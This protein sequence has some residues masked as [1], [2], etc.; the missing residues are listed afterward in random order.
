MPSLQRSCQACVRS[1]RRCDR[2]T[3]VCGRCAKR[4]VC[5]QYVNSPGQTQAQVQDTISTSQS[6]S[7]IDRPDK[8]FMPEVKRTYDLLTLDR[9]KTLLLGLPNL[10]SVDKSTVFIQPN[11]YGAGNLPETLNE[12]WSI[13][14]CASGQYF[15][16]KGFQQA[17]TRFIHQGSE[18]TSYPSLLIH[19][20]S[21]LILSIP[22]LLS[23][24]TPSSLDTHAL[25]ALSHR[26]WEESPSSVEGLSR[27]R[28]WLLAESARRAILVCNMLLRAWQFMEQGYA[29][30]SLCIEALPFD[31]RTGLWEITCEEDWKESS[32]GCEEELISVAEFVNGN[33]DE[34]GMCKFKEL[35][36]VAFR[37]ARIYEP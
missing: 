19:V 21:S 17:I 30:Q 26:L 27:W 29:T 24:S 13:L 37:K 12:A 5:C 32:G 18:Q 25:W 36:L 8:A 23:P 34:E 10:F 20:Q 16:T 9:L 33:F 7:P 1:R 11:L 35:V 15:H 6:F 22:L 28:T 14:R 2:A 4:G 31:F 3:P